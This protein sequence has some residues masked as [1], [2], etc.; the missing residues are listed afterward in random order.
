M[1]IMNAI[2]DELE[3]KVKK[4]KKIELNFQGIIYFRIDGGTKSSERQKF[5]N[6]FQNK[7]SEMQ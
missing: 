5:V 4:K 2:Q 7:N 6:Y 1:E 3:R